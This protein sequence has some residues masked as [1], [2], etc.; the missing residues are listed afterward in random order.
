MTGGG[1][2]AAA[3][4][5]HAPHALAA[6]PLDRVGTRRGDAE[7]VAARMADPASR[8]VPFWR[9][10]N[11]V[12]FDNN[13]PAAVLL[14]ASALPP[15]HQPPALLGLDGERAVFAVD[16]TPLE[17]PLP[18]S[19]GEFE[20]LW[21]VGGMMRAEDAALLG[22]AKALMHWQARHRFCGVCGAACLPEQAGHVLRCTGCGTS[23]FPRTDPAVI[24]LVTHGDRA[25]LAR[26]KRFRDVRVFSTLAGFVEPGESLEEAVAREVLEEAGVPVA[27]VRYHSSQPWPFPASVMLGFRA[28]AL[29]DAITLGD[30]ELVE[31]GWFSRETLREPEG[32]SLPPPFSIARRLIEDWM[33]A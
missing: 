29:D 12:R 1:P 24:M 16:L 8:F 3:L 32:F 5:A 26:S 18:Q 31:A 11:L 14:E 33:A 30:D 17:S 7:W 27:S 13:V 25:L 21:R 15:L 23:H 6:N 20:D 10:R 19:V 9:G 28:E 22:H 2:S 4:H